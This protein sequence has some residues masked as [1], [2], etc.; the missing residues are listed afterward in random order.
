MIR[1]FNLIL[2]FGICLMICLFT[3]CYLE[4]PEFT[5][6]SDPDQIIVKVGT[7]DTSKYYK[8]V[9]RNNNPLYV[10]ECASTPSDLVNVQI[11]QDTSNDLQQ[12]RLTDVGNGYYKITS[13]NYQDY[14]ID[15]SEEYPPIDNA[16]VQVWH[17]MNNNRQKWKFID[18]GDGYYKIELQFDPNYCIT[19]SQETPANGSNVQVSVYSA[20]DRQQW[21]L[22]PVE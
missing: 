21:K 13:R 14:C 11:G 20:N 7:F 6:T 19:E 22:V 15:E 1:K 9:L 16:N 18:V 10:L 17:Y 12:W 4:L 3:M 5:L 8:I 2:F